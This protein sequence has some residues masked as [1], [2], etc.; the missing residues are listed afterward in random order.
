MGVAVV[1]DKATSSCAGHSRDPRGEDFYFRKFGG[2]ET[3]G[4]TAKKKVFS[5]PPLC[6]QE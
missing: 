2:G 4:A 1:V 3:D 6:V 5:T